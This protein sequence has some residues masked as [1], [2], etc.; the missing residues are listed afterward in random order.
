MAEG[1]AAG[2]RLQKEKLLASAKSWRTVGSVWYWVCFIGGCAGGGII[3]YGGGDGW[4]IPAAIGLGSGLVGMGICSAIASN[5]ENAAASIASV[6]FIKQD[7]NLGNNR[8][9][10]G[11]NLMNDKTR[12]VHA[13]GLG[14]SLNF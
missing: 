2:N 5:K 3:T 4:W 11:I 8:L 9:S 7:Y 6:P 10:A 14:L 12:N 13:L 1:I